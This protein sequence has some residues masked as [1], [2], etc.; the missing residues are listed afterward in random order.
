MTYM[1]AMGGVLPKHLPKSFDK[2]HHFP[3][4]HLKKT[5]NPVVHHQG[6]SRRWGPLPVINGVIAPKNETINR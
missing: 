6:T 3:S 4:K 1:D 5:K 2:G